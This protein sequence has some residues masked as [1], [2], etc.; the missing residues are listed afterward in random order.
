MVITDLVQTCG[1]C[2]SQWEFT[3]DDFREAYVRYRHGYLSVRVG[4]K[5][6]D[7]GVEGFEIL[8]ERIGGKHDGVISW[9]GVMEWLS[10]F[11]SVDERIEE[12][13]T[14]AIT[15]VGFYTIREEDEEGDMFRWLTGVYP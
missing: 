12:I 10:K 9:D 7:S 13:V 5:V 11:S 2:P 15:K 14:E 1:A 4:K 6:G 3:T 8:G